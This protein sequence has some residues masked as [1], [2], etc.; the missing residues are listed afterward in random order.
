MAHA[1]NNASHTSVC[2]EL[3][4]TRGSNRTNSSLVRH[5]SVTPWSFYR[6]GALSISAGK[7]I[8]RVAGSNN[9]KLGDFRGYDHGAL[10][11]YLYD[12]YSGGL[13]YGP[14]GASF[15][16]TTIV[17]LEQLNVREV[18]SG[19]VP[20]IIVKYY[21]TA[22]DRTNGTNVIKTLS[23]LVS[24]S[25]VTPPT[26][27]TNNQTAK[28]ASASQVINDTFLVADIPT[29]N[30]VYLDVYIGNNGGSTVYGRFGTVI[31]DSYDEVTI[32]ENVA[33]YITAGSNFSPAP[34]GQTAAFPLVY[35][36]TSVCGT[37]NITQSTGGNTLQFYIN[38]KSV[39]ALGGRV[40]NLT[41]ATVSVTYD[42][43]S[44]TLYTGAIRVASPTTNK[45]YINSTLPTGKTWAY[46]KVAVINITSP[47]WGATWVSCP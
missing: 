3:G 21:P 23:T 37:T 2:A 1:L 31:A 13:Y 34:G 18:T 25:G 22:T 30:T 16:F 27:H 10:T 17:Y 42:G 7:F 24:E 36:S 15:T 20:Y 45:H 11:P 38:A 28:P 4:I 41:N 33:P 5:S 19:S 35:T 14:G 9:D 26:G 12:G 46:N 40:Y 6:P 44:K 32:T 39:G 47:T 8:T 43:A 29:G